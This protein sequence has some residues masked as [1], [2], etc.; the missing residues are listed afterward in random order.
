MRQP[1]ATVPAYITKDG[2]T[3]RELM[4]PATHRNAQQ[5]LAEATVPAGTRTLMHRHVRSE[6][7][8]HV[9]SGRGRMT[10]G[11]EQ[12]DIVTGDTVFIAPG[13]AHCVEASGS[14]AVT[15]LCCC[16]PPY[17]H[18]DTELIGVAEEH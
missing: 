8:Y 17:A 9:T 11:T 15:I 14:E 10:L 5:S 6:E 12:F 16:A 13:V 2:S 1:Y 3:I 4:H 18:D 7:I